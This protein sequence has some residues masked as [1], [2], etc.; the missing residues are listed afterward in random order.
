MKG[1]HW[2]ESLKILKL[3][4]TRSSTLVAPP[5]VVHPTHWDSSNHGVIPHPSFADSEVFMK[6]ELPGK[7]FV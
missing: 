5:L 3:V 4:V 6:K 1:P 2:K 7:I